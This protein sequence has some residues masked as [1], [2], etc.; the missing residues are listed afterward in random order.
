MDELENTCRLCATVKSQNELVC[1]IANRTLNIEQKLIDCCRWAS[2]GSCGFENWP[3]RICG[4]C[5][6]QLE[7]SWTFAENVAKAQEELVSYMTDV[8][9]EIFL[10][11]VASETLLISEEDQMEDARDSG[12]INSLSNCQ[13]TFPCHMSVGQDDA[14]FEENGTVLPSVGMQLVSLETPSNELPE[15]NSS[16]GFLCDTCGN[17]FSNYS[18]LMAHRRTHLPMEQRRSFECYICKTIFRYKKSLTHHMRLHSGRKVQHQCS[19]CL[20]QF[21][22]TDALRRHSLIHL[23]QQPHRCMTCG[24]GFRTKFNLTVCSFKSKTFL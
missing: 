22:R 14:I 24:K 6:E 2:I 4:S 1:S 12:A 7:K 3:H 20:A 21:S 16:I 5:Y 10:I 23:G 11:P 9:S 8:K 17:N 18:N 19:V 15:P 13:N